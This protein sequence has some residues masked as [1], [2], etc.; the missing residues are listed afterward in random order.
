MNAGFSEVGIDWACSCVQA[1]NAK[2]AV[3][4]SSA[5]GTPTTFI[6]LARVVEQTWGTGKPFAP[7]VTKERETE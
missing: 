5:A 1:A 3:S 2:P 4:N 7:A 6:R